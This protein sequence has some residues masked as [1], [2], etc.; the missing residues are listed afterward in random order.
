MRKSILLL[1][2]CLL[3]TCISAEQ[4]SVFCVNGLY[5]KPY[6]R[7][8]V[9]LVNPANQNIQYQGDIVIPAKVRYGKRKY[10]VV[11]IDATAFSDCDKLKSVTL[12]YTVKSIGVFCFLNDSSLTEVVLPKKLKRLGACAFAYC[13]SLEQLKLPGSLEEINESPFMQ[14]G[15]KSLDISALDSLFPELCSSCTQLETVVLPKNTTQLPKGCFSGCTSLKNIDLSSIVTID[16]YALASLPFDTLILPPTL[17]TMGKA[18]FAYCKNLEY[19]ELP[20]SLESIG[21]QAF[22][23]CSRLKSLRIPGSVTYIDGRDLLFDCGALESLEISPDNP[24]YYSHG[25]AIYS[26]AD[27]SLVA[28]KYGPQSQVPQ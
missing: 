3:V 9:S 26:K 15:L 28:R 16:D 10:K 27:S 25:T 18:A 23:G 13:R 22:A 20:E 5:Y 6:A 19:I 14:S 17:K 8:A 7:R 2:C 11:D 21:C 12:P 24:H 1:L 4:T